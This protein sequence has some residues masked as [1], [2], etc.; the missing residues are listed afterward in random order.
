MH[1]TSLGFGGQCHLD[2]FV[3]QTIRDLPADYI[4]LKVG[5]NIV[6]QNSLGRRAFASALHGFL[7]ID[8]RGSPCSDADTVN[9]PDLLSF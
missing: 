1:L 8:P 7:D 6:N 3:A 5:I 4:S 2:L 9:L